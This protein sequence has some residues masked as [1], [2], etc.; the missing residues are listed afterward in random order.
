MPASANEREIF[1][2]F[3]KDNII[4]P[5]RRNCR[6]SDARVKQLT[7]AQFEPAAVGADNVPNSRYL[8]KRVRDVLKN[9]GHLTTAL[10][11]VTEG[12]KTKNISVD[13]WVQR[14]DICNRVL[15]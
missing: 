13:T 3:V 11:P 8:W 5:M 14:L 10:Y 2:L 7:A 12:G 1:R 4:V 6:W 9:R 15:H